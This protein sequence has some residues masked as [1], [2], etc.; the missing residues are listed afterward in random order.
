MKKNRVAL[1][2]D[3][4]GSM[5]GIKSAAIEMFNSQIS[6]LS[7][8]TQDMDTTLSLFTFAQTADEPTVF[9]SPIDKVY[10][11]TPENYHPS[12]G[13]AL[14][15]SMGMAIDRLSGLTE[16][17]DPDC[18]FLVI[19]ITDGDENSSKHF[20]GE[21]LSDRITLLQKTGRWTFV[22]CGANLDVE[23]MAKHLHI[24][25]Q[26]TVAWAGTIA[27]AQTVT[28]ENYQATANYMNARQAGG[29]STRN[30]YDNNT[31]MGGTVGS[32]SIGSNSIAEQVRKMNEQK[33]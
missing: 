20:T 33:K 19:A 17:S 29:T 31:T 28:N 24:P 6:A 2:L 11:L 23:K 30:F 18:S 21:R 4:S 16:M 7:E 1:V 22:F 13:T 26:N 5:F 9:N 27:G 3:R 15:D 14:Y 10:K 8:N 12:G 25:Q 32:N